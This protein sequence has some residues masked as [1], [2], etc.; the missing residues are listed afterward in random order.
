M[1]FI[2]TFIGCDSHVIVINDFYQGITGG[3]VAIVR[4]KGFSSLVFV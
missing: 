3:F 2:C 1:Y 4:S